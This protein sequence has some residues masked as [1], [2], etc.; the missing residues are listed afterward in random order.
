MLMR[1]RFA[2]WLFGS[3]VMRG[4]RRGLLR[5]VFGD[6]DLRPVEYFG[7]ATGLATESERALRAAGIDLARV[8]RARTD[9]SLRSHEVDGLIALGEALVRDRLGAGPGSLA[10]GS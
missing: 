10:T 8:R 1:L 6:R 2:L 7:L 9:L 4:Q 3:V 5:R